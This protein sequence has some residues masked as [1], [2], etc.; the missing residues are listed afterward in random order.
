[1]FLGAAKKKK[2]L[3]MGMSGSEA[4]VPEN[5]HIQDELNNIISFSKYDPHCINVSC[6]FLT[7]P[8][9]SISQTT[10]ADPG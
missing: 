2:D 8:N 1:M 7:R 5:R 9:T 3:R 4:D 10:K 6:L